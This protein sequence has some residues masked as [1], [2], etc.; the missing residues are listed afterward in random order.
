MPK[1]MHIT[2]KKDFKHQIELK[3]AKIRKKY[4]HTKKH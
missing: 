4:K 1:D 2:P 3:H